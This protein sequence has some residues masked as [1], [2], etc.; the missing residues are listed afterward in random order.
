LNTTNA[1]TLREKL[2]VFS[3]AAVQRTIER[4]AQQILE[5]NGA[6]EHLMLI[7]IRK[8]GE[9][10]SRRIFAEIHKRT[11]VAVPVGFLNINLYR[12]DDTR[13]ELPESDI[14]ADVTARELVLIDDVLFTGRTVRAAL[15][16]LTDRGRPASIRLC[17]MVD[18]G[19]RDFPIQADYVGR[20]VPTSRAE[21]IVVNLRPEPS[22][23]D[24]V[25]IC[26]RT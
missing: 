1:P 4:L 7:G 22:E 24:R 19:I 25:V 8:G 26:E 14:A 11:G 9:N 12:D 21:R 2:V 17:V 15:D 16:A 23:S 3:S 5:P 20:F 18:R 13:R 6:G 10:L